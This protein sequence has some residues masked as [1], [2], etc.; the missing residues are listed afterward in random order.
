[1]IQKSQCISNILDIYICTQNK[2]ILVSFY[3]VDKMV[4]FITSKSCFIVFIHYIRY[5][6]KHSQRK[7]I[8]YHTITFRHKTANQIIFTSIY[9]SK[10]IL[11]SYTVQKIIWT[12]LLEMLFCIFFDQMEGLS[13]HEQDQVPITFEQFHNGKNNL[14][15]GI[16]ET[17][18]KIKEKYKWPGLTKDVQTFIKHC[19]ISEKSKTC[20]NNLGSPLVAT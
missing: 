10:D 20:R 9:K 13:K 6:L 11:P 1:M 12:I 19:K 5:I 8:L 14:H 16:Y 7:A 15:R 2:Y 17:I 18:R 4:T 3:N